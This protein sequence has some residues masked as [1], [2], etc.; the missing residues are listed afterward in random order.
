MCAKDCGFSNQKYWYQNFVCMFSWLTWF[1]NHRNFKKI[2]ARTRERTLHKCYNTVWVSVS[3][4]IPTHGYKDHH[5]LWHTVEKWKT[6]FI[7]RTAKSFCWPKELPCLQKWIYIT[8]WTFES[9]KIKLSK[10]EK[11]KKNRLLFHSKSIPD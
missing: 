8:E 7:L 10:T 3:A 5:N 2:K 1:L 11:C 6:I 4:R 9:Y